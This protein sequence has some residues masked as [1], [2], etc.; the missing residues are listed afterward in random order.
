[1]DSITIFNALDTNVQTIFLMSLIDLIIDD[2]KQSQ[3]YSVASEAVGKCWEWIGNKNVSADDLYD[4]LEN[5]DETGVLTY[6]LLEKDQHREKVWICLSNA[7]VYTTWAAYQYENRKYRPE[8]IECVD[9]E[10]IISFI[11][12]FRIVFSS[13][14]ILDN[15]LSY[16]FSKKATIDREEIKLY[17]LGELH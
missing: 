8:T 2:I 4:C 6:L 3:G 1:M 11:E 5:I 7:L 9:S 12:N 17:I 13:P 10:T 15:L 16:L 14:Q